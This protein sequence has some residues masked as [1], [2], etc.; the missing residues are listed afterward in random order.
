M[1]GDSESLSPGSRKPRVD[2]PWLVMG[3]QVIEF[4]RC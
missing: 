2:W 1:A 4:D 3:F